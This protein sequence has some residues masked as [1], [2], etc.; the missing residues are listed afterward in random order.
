MKDQIVP[1][2]NNVL[3]ERQTRAAAATN[4]NNS[5]SLYHEEYLLQGDLESALKKVTEVISETATKLNT[6]IQQRRL[7]KIFSKETQSF[8]NDG[9]NDILRSRTDENFDCSDFL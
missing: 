6:C 8:K 3:P 2:T 9:L 7:W 5:Y 1:E 4:P